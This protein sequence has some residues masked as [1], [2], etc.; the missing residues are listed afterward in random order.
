MTNTTFLLY[1]LLVLLSL[2]LLMEGYSLLRLREASM[3]KRRKYLRVKVPNDKAITCRVVEPLKEA[4]A[5]E[6]LVDDITMAGICFYADHK[7]DKQI[8]K[9][10]IK[11]P[12]M[13]F[14]DAATVWGKVVYSNRCSNEDRFRTGI[15]YMR[16]FAK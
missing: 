4:G 5:K 8:V 7:L 6:F 13:T 12:F 11:F 9:L 16:R 3:K 2:L 14:K 1:I 10:N 15:S